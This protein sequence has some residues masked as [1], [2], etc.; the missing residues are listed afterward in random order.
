MDAVE[1]Q[2]TMLRNWHGN[3]PA[4]RPVLDQD[5]AIITVNRKVLSGIIAGLPSTVTETA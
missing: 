2:A 3:L 5:V 1:W 4:Q